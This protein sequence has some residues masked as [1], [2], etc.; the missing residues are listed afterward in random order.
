M[1]VLLTDQ[2]DEPSDVPGPENVT[3]GSVT[4][5]EKVPEKVT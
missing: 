2:M 5:K 4:R 3:T 1:D